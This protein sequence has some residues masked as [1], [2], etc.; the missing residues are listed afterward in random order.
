MIA[1][2]W[3]KVGYVVKRY[4]R[5]SE[6][7][8]VNEI[9]AHEA[10]GWEL[11]IYALGFPYEAHFQDAISR[12]HAP[13]RYLQAAES[14]TAIDFWKAFERGSELFPGMWN[15]LAL[16]R[17]E[18]FRHV[19]QAVSL[20][21]EIRLNGIQHLHAHFA[22]G[23]ASV[24][25]LAACFAA[26]P[27][28]ITAHAK[29]IF[30]E[31]VSVDDLRRKFSAAAAVVTVSDYNVAY[32]RELCGEMAGKVRRIYNG[33]DLALF[34]YVEPAEREQRIIAVGRLVEKK[35]FADLIEACALLA[36][37]GLE[38]TCQIVGAGELELE[39]RQRISDSQVSDVV[40][41]TGPKPQREVIDLIR[42]AAVLA[43]PCVL[44]VDGN[45]DGLPTVLLEAMA[46]GTPCIATD[47]VGIPEVVRPGETGLLVNERSPAQLAA[48]MKRLLSEPDLRVQ[49]ATAA[50]QLIE[51]EF[52]LHR[53]AARL[54]ELFRNGAQP[55][56]N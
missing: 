43:A 35:G 13:V 21:C 24:A 36:Q 46:L 48:A 47:V 11:E 23:A 22:T 41:L 14:L 30:H 49:L 54:R 18:D 34:P 5:F 17:G 42:R 38:F 31:S 51:T 15:Q 37:E 55:G 27:Y 53:N 28:T 25:R 52:G 50:R 26:I 39:L 20:A 40:E 3:P 9:L 29:D 33:V 7:F 16:A 32:L 45:R 44:G 10:E 2:A 56:T 8:I 1:R 19:Y 12:V 4:P 6:T